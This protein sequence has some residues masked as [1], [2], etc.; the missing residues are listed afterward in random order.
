MEKVSIIV[1]VYN[2]EKVIGRCIDSILKQDYRDIEVLLIDDGSRD[3]SWDIIQEYAAREERIVAVHKENG[4]VSSTRNRGLSLASGKYVQFIDA[5]DWLPFESTKLMVRALEENE[6]DMAVGDF[7]RVVGD[8]VAKKGSISEGGLLSRLEYADKMLLSPADFYYGVLWNKLYKKEIIDQHFLAMD[9]NISYCEDMIFNLEYMLYVRNIAV[10]KAPVYYYVR[11]E[12]SLIEKNMNVQ[13]IVKMKS[14]V[15]RYYDGFYKN[16]MDR[17]D[18]QQ[19]K[20]VIYGYLLAVSTDSLAM[21]LNLATKKLGEETGEKNFYDQDLDGTELMRGYLNA[22]L[23]NQYL[24]T[25]GHQFRLDSSDMK[26]LYVLYL[27]KGEMETDRLAALAGVSEVNLAIIIARLAATGYV[28]INTGSL[29]ESGRITCSYVSGRLDTSFEQLQKD[30]E[31]V[32]YEGFSP[33][34]KQEYEALKDRAYSNIRKKF[35]R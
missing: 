21:P 30:Y 4:G 19:R 16:I 11:T 32:C 26:I 12:G 20:P 33:E 24:L 9:D 27:K 13:S 23:I 17:E 1:P 10:I 7:Y 2:A 14:S 15:I 34:E 22:R 35:D 25:I 5:D 8:N 3:S 18:Y 31:S 6:A 29:L 28:R